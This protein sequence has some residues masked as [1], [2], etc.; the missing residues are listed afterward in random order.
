MTAEL[1]TVEMTP[2]NAPMAW[3]AFSKSD[4]TT[5]ISISGLGGK[6]LG[7]NVL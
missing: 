3:L 4:E 1:G 6:S 7:I 5:A 2:F